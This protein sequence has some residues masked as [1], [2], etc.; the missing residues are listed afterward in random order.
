MKESYD[1]GLAVHINPELCASARKGWLEALTGAH[2]G[3]TLSRESDETSRCR[4]SIGRRKAIFG[5]SISE[6]QRNLA[7]SEN[8]CMHGNTSR[9]NW[10][11]PC[12]PAADGA[13]GRNGKFENVIQR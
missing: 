3:R 4:R 12:S 10:E 2:A 11:V 9:K 8:P 7:W 5:A 1:K 13:A 6:T